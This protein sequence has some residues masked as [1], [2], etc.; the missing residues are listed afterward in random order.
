[1]SI[2]V[3]PIYKWSLKSSAYTLYRTSSLVGD[4]STTGNNVSLE[5]FNVV[6]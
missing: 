5:T 4:K 1:M 6:T 2:S 3:I